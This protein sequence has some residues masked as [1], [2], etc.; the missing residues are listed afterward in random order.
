MFRCVLFSDSLPLR[1]PGRMCNVYKT[2][3]NLLLMRIKK[4]P[5][6]T[7]FTKLPPE[8][9]VSATKQRTNTVGSI[10]SMSFVVPL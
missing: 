8:T 2:L 3:L 4:T 9:T 10:K 1:L 6:H 7:Q 5:L